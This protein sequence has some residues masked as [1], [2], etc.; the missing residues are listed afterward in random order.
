METYEAIMTRRS[1]PKCSDQVPDRSE[2]KR[3]LDAAVRAPTHHLTQPWRFVVLKDSALDDFGRAWVEGTEREGKDASGIFD[4]AHRAPVVI[5]VI[6]RPH[7]DNRKVVKEE[8]HYATGAALQNILLAAHDMGLAAMLRTGPAVFMPEVRALLN[9][10]DDEHIAG[11]IYLG[12]PA[13]GSDERP[14]T[15]RKPADELTEWRGFHE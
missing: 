1:V 8:E 4:K 2:I 11:L 14:M 3:L 10:G 6:E 12:Y 5:A 13:E 9:V 7:L 15:R